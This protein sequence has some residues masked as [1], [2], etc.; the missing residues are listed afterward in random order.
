MKFI[1]SWKNKYFGIE[2]SKRRQYYIAYQSYPEHR[3]FGY[4]DEWYDGPIK[5]YSLWYFFFQIVW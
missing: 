3:F 4:T 1:G 2:T 5:T